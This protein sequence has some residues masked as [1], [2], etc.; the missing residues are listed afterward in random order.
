MLY[1]LLRDQPRCKS[2]LSGLSARVPIR[3]CRG[4]IN[5][6]PIVIKLA[7]FAP[8]V[9][10]N[11]DNVFHCQFLAVRMAGRC[12]VS[13]WGRWDICRPQKLR[14][15]SEA[16]LRRGGSFYT[17]LVVIAGWGWLVKDR[18]T[19]KIS[20]KTRNDRPVLALV[21]WKMGPCLRREDSDWG[22]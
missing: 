16:D 3:G 7:F 20:R 11:V 9:K 4:Q 22:R 13:H 2:H 17:R 10:G 15:E 1:R 14:T 21:R 19:G 18:V 5:P 8:N 12:R 6:P